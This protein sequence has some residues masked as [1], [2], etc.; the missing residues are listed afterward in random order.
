MPEWDGGRASPET[1]ETNSV[2]PG[3]THDVVGSGDVSKWDS[4][5][6][7]TTERGSAPRSGCVQVSGSSLQRSLQASRLW[8]LLYPK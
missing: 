6:F 7:E 5:P 8:L 3:R 4:P 1:S 2:G